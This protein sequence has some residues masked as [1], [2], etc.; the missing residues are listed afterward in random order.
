[1][2]FDAA[3]GEPGGFMGQGLGVELSH[4]VSRV[5]A[6]LRSDKP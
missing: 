3:P 1:M 5:C 2:W 6:I 4:D